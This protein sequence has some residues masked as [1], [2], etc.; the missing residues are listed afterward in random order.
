M[1]ATKYFTASPINDI[2][3]KI[4]ETYFKRVNGFSD[5]DV[6]LREFILDFAEIYNKFTEKYSSFTDFDAED[7]IRQLFKKEFQTNKITRKKAKIEDFEKLR[8]DGL[9]EIDKYII[10]VYC[11]VRLKEN[12][13]AISEKLIQKL[14]NDIHTVQSSISSKNYESNSTFQEQVYTNSQPLNTLE[15]FLLSQKSEA[16]G[17]KKGYVFLWG[18]GKRQSLTGTEEFVTLVE[19]DEEGLAFSPA[20]ELTDEEIAEQL[21]SDF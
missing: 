5:S 9:V 12:N 8:E 16:T 20:P 1:Y 17:N 6:I 10:D 14:V 7:N 11:R 21:V 3:E 18:D 19:T 13:I 15:A 2:P 4:L